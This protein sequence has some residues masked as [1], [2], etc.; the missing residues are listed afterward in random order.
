[1]PKVVHPNIAG[2]RLASY[3]SVNSLPKQEALGQ[4][5]QDCMGT[6]FTVMK[7]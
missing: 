4:P 6:E 1:M 5:I 7:E 2:T 3:N